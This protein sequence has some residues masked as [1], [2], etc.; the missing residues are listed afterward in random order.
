MTV[1]TFKEEANRGVN[2]YLVRMLKELGYRASLHAVP[3]DQ[4]YA[5]AGN[6]SHKIQLGLTGWAATSPPRLTSSCPY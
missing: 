6:C 4:F 1:W 2:A 3:I 5:M